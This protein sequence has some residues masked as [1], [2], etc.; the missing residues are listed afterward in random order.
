MGQIWTD[1]TDPTNY[2]REKTARIERSF[3][4]ERAMGPGIT[5]HSGM[6]ERR[7]VEIAKEPAKNEY[8]QKTIRTIWNWK[9]T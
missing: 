2:H 8:H 5:I 1:L 7:S 6:D 9:R 4:A 3:R